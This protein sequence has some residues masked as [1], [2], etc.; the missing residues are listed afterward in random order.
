ME[1]AVSVTSTEQIPLIFDVDVLVIGGWLAGVSAAHG[2]ASRGLRVAL[3]ESG[4]FLGHELTAW[5][6]PW[7][8]WRTQD[9]QTL[10]TWFPVDESRVSKTE[11]A[12]L[13]LR[14][15]AI[16]LKLE[17]RIL[18]AGVKLLYASR[19][20]GYRRDGDRW[21]VVIG[22][23]SG[24]QAI[25]TRYIVDAT[26]I[27]LMAHLA[28]AK[29]VGE[30]GR[31][32]NDSGASVVHRTIEFIGVPQQ[33]VRQYDVPP[34]LGVSGSKLT[35]Y[36]GGASEDHVYVDIP[37]A[38]EAAGERSL[39]ADFDVE[40]RSRAKSLEVAEYLCTKAEAFAR[41]SAS[42]FYVCPPA[43]HAKGQLGLGSS[44]VMRGEGYSPVAAL[45][46]GAA[47]ANEISNGDAD[48]ADCHF[49]SGTR[50]LR[51]RLPDTSLAMAGR[52]DHSIAYRDESELRADWPGENVAAPITSIPV[53]AE[54]DVAVIGGGTSGVPAA[55]A[56]ARE[57]V[58]T[59]L[60]DMNPSL[61]G[62]GTLGGIN[63]YWMSDCTAYSREIDDRVTVW[64]LRL[65]YRRTRFEGA[66]RE[67]D[68]RYRYWG[69]D[70]MWSIEVKAQVLA[71]MCQEAGA[72]IYPESL[73][74]GTLMNGKKVAGT[75]LATPYG[76]RAVLSRISV[77]ATG[78][79]DV[80]AFGG[81]EYV[82]G[83]E[84]DKMTMWTS[85][86]YFG[87][88]GGLGNNH[89]TAADVA[90]IF[91]Y[92]RFILT[93]R[94]RG[95]KLHDHGTYVAPRQS[96]HI[97]GE[98]TLTLKDEVLLAH[99]PD[100][101]AVMYS[102]YDMKGVQ[103]ADL[104][105]FGIHPPHLHI[106]IPYR[107][108]VPKELDSLFISGKAFS[109]THDASAAPRMQRDIQLLGGVTGLAAAMAVRDGVQPRFLSVEKLR[110]R[111]LA[112]KNLPLDIQVQREGSPEKGLQECI[113]AVSCEEESEW[114]AKPVSEA[115]ESVSPLLRLCYAESS[116][117]VPLLRE[118]FA[119]A[120][121]ER[122]LLLAKLLLWHR[123]Q[124]GV[125]AVVQEVLRQCRSCDGI[126]PRHGRDWGGATPDHGVVPETAALL[127]ALS[128]VGSLAVL[129]AFEAVVDRL[130][131]S[132]RNYRDHKTKVFSHI[133][134][135]A[136]GAE[137]LAIPDF[138]PMLERLLAFPELQGAIRRD[139]PE[140]DMFEERKAMLVLYLARAL[141]RC[142]SRSGLLQLADLLN[143]QRSL[144]AKSALKELRD[145][146][147]LSLPRDRDRWREALASLPETAPPQPWEL[148]LG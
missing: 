26:D 82:Y 64:H 139:A 42:L 102:N 69:G 73:C 15:D 118:A 39:E 58:Q 41:K 95:R 88:P 146:T 38:F 145:L 79:G 130:E 23:K 14:M 98:T 34:D 131:K 21:L 117:V 135:V 6:R 36:P 113:D 8:Q 4:T 81:A 66:R 140:I 11:G 94:R 22:N 47:L 136:M 129:P 52:S 108:L 25:A 45:D 90:D 89:T 28:G 10:E 24:R 60:V 65:G 141:A 104:V 122:R 57:G 59:V 123:C 9:R 72:A 61:G 147:G 63:A 105:N 148:E 49:L 80:A 76:P 70:D 74:I 126:P 31:P 32:R 87:E 75:V 18:S 109:Q 92:T 110:Q 5:Q 29:P 53:L 111:L 97:L 91:D 103:V 71:E 30:D 27:S 19:P 43:S 12:I 119:K 44:Q 125:D 142:G 128:R 124:E 144:I 106:E 133:H 132:E 120:S 51:L 138:V 112:D 62:T 77:D 7:V 54:A 13:P 127:F 78:D 99:H 2:A 37:L 48:P 137:R 121:G 107:A 143:D 33:D 50:T 114:L 86:A 35:F 85:L 40:M 83:S 55:V 101:I 84:R 96:R 3:I 56:A 93:A 16:K 116:E 17:D 20:I 134:A 68:G 67:A 100:T 1:R 46:Q 115:A